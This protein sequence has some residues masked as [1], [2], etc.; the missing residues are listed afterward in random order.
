[1]LRLFC[2]MYLHPAKTLTLLGVWPKPIC[3]LKKYV[4]GYVRYV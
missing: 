4:D 3:I 2:L 1:M